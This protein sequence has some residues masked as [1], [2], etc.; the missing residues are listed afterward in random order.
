MIDRMGRAL[1]IALLVSL[2]AAGQAPDAATAFIRSDQDR[3]VKELI[4]LTEIPSPPFK[5][6]A[7]AAAFAEL[8]GRS[9]LAGVETD[10]EGNVMALRKGAGRGLLV[11]NAHLDTV[12][13]EGTNVRVK[14][15]GTRLSAPG[16]G[17]DTRG[18]ALLLS[19]VRAMDAAKTQ[20]ASDILFVGNVGEEGE[21]DLRGIK[22]LLQK[23]K[24]T[25][26]VTQMIAIDGG[27]V[28]GVTTGGVGSKR[29]RV[30]FTGPGGHS[31]G[32]FGLVNPAFAM[33]DAIARFSRLTVPSTPKTT[34]NVGVVRGGTS[35]N[36]IPAEMSM[37]IDMRSESCAELAKVDAAFLQIVRG[38]VDAENKARSTKE[39]PV[40][41]EP[42][43][44]GERPCGETPMSSPIVQ[45]ADAA[46]RAFGMTPSF[47]ISSTDANVPMN[48]GIPAITIGRGGPGGRQHSPDEWTDVNP[49]TNV[50][51]EQVVLAIIVAAAGRR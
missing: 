7:R 29:Y 50:K 42:T 48:M 9:G 24:Y 16:V 40:K 49:A 28:N 33:G 47:T 1:L 32:A 34:F 22:Y 36:S 10:S 35:I 23:G 45:A 6:Q 25:G 37:D 30:T 39:G 26:Q 18:L 3:F 46:I 5:E 4:A 14:R 15:Q 11:V 19:V 41:A 12:F 21:G 38:A 2:A 17:D 51:N 13:P 31:Y 20:T 27:D 44:V 43:V 8:L